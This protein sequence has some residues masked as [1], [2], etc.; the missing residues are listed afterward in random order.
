MGIKLTRDRAVRVTKANGLES[1]LVEVTK[2]LAG[3]TVADL[4]QVGPEF[5]GMWPLPKQP[6]GS[7]AGSTKG[8]LLARRGGG[9]LAVDKFTGE[10]EAYENAEG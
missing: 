4:T 2:D 8:L 6:S 10:C 7:H 9:V 5:L 3:G 1:G